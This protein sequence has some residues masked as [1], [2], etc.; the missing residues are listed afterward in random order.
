MRTLLT[1]TAAATTIIW[2]VFDFYNGPSLVI[3]DHSRV[4]A[5]SNALRFF[6]NDGALYCQ[7]NASFEVESKVE[8][9]ETKEDLGA[10][11]R[12]AWGEDERQVVI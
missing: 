7:G 5:P 6:R 10:V 8:R 3:Q 4:S 2:W 11:I 1:F 12:G 9:L